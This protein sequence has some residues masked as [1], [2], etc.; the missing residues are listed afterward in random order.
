MSDEDRVL[1]VPIASI[2]GDREPFNG[3]RGVEE[4]AINL[5]EPLNSGRFRFLRRDILERQAKSEGKLEYKQIVPYMMFFNPDTFQVYAFRHC[6]NSRDRKTILDGMWYFGFGTN[7]E[8]SDHWD[9]SRDRRYLGRDLIERAKSRAIAEMVKSNG[10]II[11]SK[12]IGF[13]NEEDYE[14]LGL[15]KEEFERG[16]L[17][18][19]Y[20]NITNSSTMAPK[21]NLPL[22]GGMC[23]IDKLGEIYS[24]SFEDERVSLDPWAR[25]TYTALLKSFEFH[26]SVSSKNGLDEEDEKKGRRSK[27]HGRR[28]R[29]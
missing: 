14:E 23:G 6:P 10:R 15:E 9:G 17:A 18:P 5:D 20:L 12:L 1:V 27:K 13:I 4:F 26:D 2:F 25:M 21:N 16:I 22:E 29:R 7:I 19:V 24:A 3:F 11:E 28:D 8:L